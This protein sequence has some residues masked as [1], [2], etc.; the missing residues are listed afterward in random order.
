MNWKKARRAAL[1][2]TILL[3]CFLLTGCFEALSVDDQ[4][5]PVAIGF[6]RGEARRFR[7]SLQIPEVK[8]SDS[9]EQKSGITLIT[10]EGDDL[11]SVKSMIDSSTPW[12]IN[13]SHVGYLIVSD[14]LARSEAMEELL[15][16]LPRF[17]ELRQ[18]NVLIIAKESAE[19]FLEGLR[20]SDDTNPGRILSDLMLEPNLT[21]KFPHSRLEEYNEALFSDCFDVA[22]ALGAFNSAVSLENNEEE[23]KS[24]DS[25]GTSENSDVSSKKVTAADSDSSSPAQ[26]LPEN[27]EDTPAG[28]SPR[29]GGMESELS[30]CAV[31]VD[32]HMVG[33]LNGRQTQLLQ[34]GRG[35]FRQGDIT[36]DGLENARPLSVHLT[37]R[38]M[39]SVSLDL[40]APSPTAKITLFVEASPYGGIT[41]DSEILNLYHP[42]ED[43]VISQKIRDY[44]QNGLEEV[45]EIC[46]Q[47]GCDLW[48]LGKYA[49]R[50]FAFVSQ[51]EDY[52]WRSHFMKTEIQWNI[53][54]SIVHPRVEFSQNQP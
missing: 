8:S 24:Q 39:P 51:W 33:E 18:S 40:S 2:I 26:P 52:R 45:E 14:E 16:D 1:S 43:S 36:L 44:L 3:S 4:S 31:F 22:V 35:T 41:Q 47:L 23:E 7:V 46:R 17:L 53:E 37:Q 28:S 9:S 54:L 32:G 48:G 12:V 38:A 25:S 15:T 29:T 5:Y 42:S 34:L 49:V 6:D 11:H 27:P 21:G 20:T 19:K 50:H 10:A 13:F 30:G